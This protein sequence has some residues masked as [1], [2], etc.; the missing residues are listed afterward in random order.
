MNSIEKAIMLSDE[1]S[2]L[3]YRILSLRQQK[4][5]ILS[6]FMTSEQ[7]R[8]WLWK[9]DLVACNDFVNQW[10]NAGTLKGW[11]VS[12]R[13]YTTEENLEAYAKSQQEKET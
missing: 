2:E 12:G 11:K 7:A 6:N 8:N 5:Q 3:H 10:I 13:S 1:I 4:K 9:R